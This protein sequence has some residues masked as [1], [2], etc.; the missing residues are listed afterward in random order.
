[1][2][3]ERRLFLR[4]GDRDAEIL[5]LVH[6]QRRGGK[7]G[8][9]AF[10]LFIADRFPLY[11]GFA[12]GRHAIGQKL[13]RANAIAPDRFQQAE[14]IGALRA[15]AFS[16]TSANVRIVGQQVIKDGDDRLTAVSCLTQ[17]QGQ[18]NGKGRAPVQPAL[19]IE[20]RLRRLPFV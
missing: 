6:A 2:V 19:I 5:F 17:G 16:Y 12:I 3:Q 14:V 4:S 15:H 1:M 20:S 18:G 10:N 8:Q 11:I 9:N 13:H 7:A